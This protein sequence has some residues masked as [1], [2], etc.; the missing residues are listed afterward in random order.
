MIIIHAQ[1][2][3]L[4]VVYRE[5]GD[6]EVEPVHYKILIEHPLIQDI[7]TACKTFKLLVGRCE[8]MNLFLNCYCA[9]V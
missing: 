2:E 4:S 1:Q 7:V 5:L 6:E 3:R 9:I 8:G